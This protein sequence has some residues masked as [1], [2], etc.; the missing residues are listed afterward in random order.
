MWLVLEEFDSSFLFNGELGTASYAERVKNLVDLRKKLVDVYFQNLRNYF[1]VYAVL[2][3][4]K[5]I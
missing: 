3:E 2:N 4:D 5:F 1:G